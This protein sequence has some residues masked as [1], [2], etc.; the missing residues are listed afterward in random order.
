MNAALLRRLLIT[1]VLL[2]L[3]TSVIFL[4]VRLLPGDPANTILGASEQF[5]P[6]A[7]QV[8]TV[9]GKL[10]LDK[11]LLEQ[12]TTYLGRLAQ[13]DL[14]TSLTS[15]RPV[16]LDLGLRLGRTLQIM[17]PALLLSSLLGIILGVLAARTRGG[18]FD[19]I[20]SLIGLLGFSV[21]VF[22]IGNLMVLV[23]AVELGWLPSSGYVDVTQDP[24]LALSYMALPIVA[25]ALGPLA[26]TMRMTR[27][28]IVEELGLDYVRT[29]RAK[30]LRERAVLYGHVL[31]N[32]LLPVVAVIG[33][34]VGSAFAGSV[35]V[36]YIFNWPGLGRLLL[37]AIEGRDYPVIQGTV[38]LSSVLF[39][40]VN[41]VTDIS[42]L[43][44][45]PRLRR[46]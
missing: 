6:S 11:P 40:L 12:Y 9:R 43:F 34:Q 3:V 17:V 32:A 37:T 10:G 13:G 36:E 4:F 45:N 35:V 24:A 2:W 46:S 1:L 27:T 29:A 22:V 33:L 20:L 26:V 16:A 7:E 44:L 31:R 5:Q 42:Y 14:G 23:F 15:G 38:L 19:P 41:L 39:V 25:L 8:A 18:L 30:G 28:T 21:P